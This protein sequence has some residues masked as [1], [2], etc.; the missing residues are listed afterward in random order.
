VDEAKLG[1]KGGTTGRRRPNQ[2]GQDQ[3]RVL[4]GELRMLA[5]GTEPKAKLLLLLLPAIGTEPVLTL[6]DTYSTLSL[7]NLLPCLAQFCASRSSHPTTC[8]LGRGRE[9]FNPSR[10]SFPDVRPPRRF[11]QAGARSRSQE[12]GAHQQPISHRNRAKGDAC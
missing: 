12:P 5:V 7:L 8:A 6:W 3:P 1:D 9:I 10:K 11:R 2:D 4:L